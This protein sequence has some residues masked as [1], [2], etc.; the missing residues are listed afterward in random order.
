MLSV[1][2]V[3]A[4]VCCGGGGGGGREERVL[5]GSS[6]HLYVYMYMRVCV[7]DCIEQSNLIAIVKGRVGG[8][9]EYCWV[10]RTWGAQWEVPKIGDILGYHKT[11][12]LTFS[13]GM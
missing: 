5:V 9:D 12:A 3:S 10:A 8:L 4:S 1:L 11:L 6:I 7:T 2:Q 13:S